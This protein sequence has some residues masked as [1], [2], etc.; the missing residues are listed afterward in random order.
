MTRYDSVV[1]EGSPTLWVI[2]VLVTGIHLAAYACVGGWLDPGHE[3]R[4][5]GGS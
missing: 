3:A 5:G 1:S 4:D 2:P